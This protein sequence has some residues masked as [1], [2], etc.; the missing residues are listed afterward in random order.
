MSENTAAYIQM[1]LPLIL[2]FF[3]L[4]FF[5]IRPQKKRDNETKKMRSSLQEGDEIVT[6]GGIIGKVLSVKDDSVVVYVGSDKTKV[7]FKK[8]AIAEVTK[9][10]ERAPKAEAPAPAEEEAPKKKIK[11]LVRKDEAD[12]NPLEEN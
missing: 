9:K 5:M 10:S 12:E 8:W 6:I 2:I 3:A 11:K 7:E 4:W 1:F